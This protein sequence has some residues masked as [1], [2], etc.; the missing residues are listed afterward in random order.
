MNEDFDMGNFG[1]FHYLNAVVLLITLFMCVWSYN[2]V[3]IDIGLIIPCIIVGI[4]LMCINTHFR[5]KKESFSKSY[6]AYNGFFS[7]LFVFSILPS[8][9][10]T[11]L[12]GDNCSMTFAPNYETLIGTLAATI[13][14]G[15]NS[16]FTGKLWIDI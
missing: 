12:I 15:L 8:L 6:M 3:K 7:L 11:G 4:V 5:I 9:Y 2:I 14:F 10:T 1:F 13:V 16:F